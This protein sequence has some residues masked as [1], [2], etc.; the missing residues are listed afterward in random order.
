MTATQL[1]AVRVSLPVAVRAA[2]A[3]REQHPEKLQAIADIL[4]IERGLSRAQFR[5]LVQA[6]TGAYVTVDEFDRLL[7]GDELEA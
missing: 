2:W 6:E 3:D 7:G 1:V 5:E 4:W